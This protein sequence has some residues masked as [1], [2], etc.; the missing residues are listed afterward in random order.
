[1][2]LGMSSWIRL[3]IDG[4]RPP[5]ALEFAPGGGA[6]YVRLSD[7]SVQRTVEVETGALADYDATGEVVGFELLDLDRPGSGEAL[8]RLKERFAEAAPELLA[9]HAPP[10]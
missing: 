10:A 9:V 8:R 5:L 2:S 6:V 4:P 1:M 7:R 3:S